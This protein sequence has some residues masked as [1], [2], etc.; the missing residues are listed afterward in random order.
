MKN[1]ATLYML[2]GILE[3]RNAWEDASDGPAC[4]FTMRP[5]LS[6]KVAC[7]GMSQKRI[8]DSW[9]N[10]LK[11][12]VVGVPRFDGLPRPPKET[13][14]YKAAEP[15]R[16][17]V[18]T[19]KTPAFTEQQAERVLGSLTDLKDFFQRTSSLNG[20]PI[21]IVWRVADSISAKLEIENT[22]HDL[23]GSELASQLANVDAVVS[24]ASTL[25]IEAMLF[26]L[27]VAL[28]DYHN[29]PA[30]V[31]TAWRIGCRDHIQPI[32]V[33]LTDP[34]ERKMLFQRTELSDAAY[35]GTN[36]AD[37]MAELIVL[38][39]KFA[40]E[41]ATDPAP[42]TFPADMLRSGT[43]ISHS[44]SQFNHAEL[45]PEFDEFRIDDRP[46]LQSQLSHARREITHLK[47]RLA[48]R[49]SELAHAHEIFD[50]INQHPVAG[51][52]VKLG[53]W[54]QG[55]GNNDQGQNKQ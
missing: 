48:I 1:V 4:P 32:V 37:R 21:E 17:L 18:A 52:L 42:I 8:L 15:F 5:V 2:D 19:A 24:T 50:R 55:L 41:H 28:L 12:E 39:Q 29:T 49:E 20:R 46:E 31:K 53:R 23:T 36:A 45:Y 33:E 22:A 26:D 11:T 51:P 13:K 10:H 16:I 6:H 35:S 30:Y 38:M 9:G 54:W 34:P 27:P 14:Q 43:S 3:W 47:N 40:I 44:N 25:M 7:I